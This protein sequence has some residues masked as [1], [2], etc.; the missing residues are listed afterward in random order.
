[1]PSGRYLTA[2]DLTNG[3]S[4]WRINLHPHLYY[5]H[6]ARVFYHIHKDVVAASSVTGWAVLAALK[7]GKEFWRKRLPGEIC[8]RP[9]VSDKSV[10]FGTCDG[11]VWALDRLTGQVLWERKTPLRAVGFTC[12]DNRLYVLSNGGDLYLLDARDGRKVWERRLGG[13]WR[14]GFLVLSGGT[15]YAFPESGR[16]G[17]P[18]G[19][20]EHF[21]HALDSKTGESL[22]AVPIKD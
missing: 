15:L 14:G 9:A 4:L 11:Y 16:G 13:K 6:K 12:E 17:Y 18:Y 1:M 19:T 7:N 20:V 8:L 3:S 21:A 10:F 22:W 5:S 2:M